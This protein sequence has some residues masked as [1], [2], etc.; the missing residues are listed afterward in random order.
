MSLKLFVNTHKVPGPPSDVKVKVE[1]STT[2]S[3]AWAKPQKPNGNILEYQIIFYG[4]K[5]TVSVYCMYNEPTVRIKHLVTIE[6][7]N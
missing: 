5:L 2:V 7:I 1:N 4:F 3:V 6:L